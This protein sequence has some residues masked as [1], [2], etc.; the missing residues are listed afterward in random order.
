MRTTLVIATLLATPL[1]A[2]A[3]PKGKKPKAGAHAKGG[4]SAKAHM[5][6]AAKAHKAGKF[7]VALEELEAA[8]AIEPQDKLLFAMAQVQQKLDRCDDAIANYE[9][10]LVTTDDKQQKSIV[11]QAISSCNKKIAAAPTSSSSTSPA[12]DSSVFR[13]QKPAEPPPAAAPPAPEPT[14]PPSPVAP[15]AETDDSPLGTRS[16]KDTVTVTSGRKPWYKD[17]LGD[18]L[19][20]GGVASGAMSVVMYTGAR[21]DLDAAEKAV[22]L[23]SYED[24]VGQA[25]DKRVYS[26]VFAGAGGVL[27]TA[28]LLRYALRGSGE[29]HTVALAPLAGGGLVTWSG[30]F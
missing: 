18:V 20:L 9:K 7:E 8:Y 3:K 19:V 28:G 27:I 22:S 29:K 24:L 4:K 23:D 26:V 30:G 15:T 21:S 1:V 6:K 5:D 25:R 11:K 10:F 2:D 12:N 14:P 13:D 16:T 17:V